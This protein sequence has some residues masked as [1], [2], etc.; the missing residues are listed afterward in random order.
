MDAAVAAALALG[1]HG[2]WIG[3]AFLVAEEGQTHAANKRQILEGRSQ[4]FEVNRYYTGKPSRMFTNAMLEAWQGSGLEPLPMPFQ[5][6]L[7]DDFNAS[8]AAAGR[9]EL[10]A[11]PAGQIAGMVRT[12][13]PAAEIFDDLVRGAV[14]VIE[15]SHACLGHQRRSRSH[16]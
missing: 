14:A 7:T 6:V 15:A 9:E 16:G 11:N 12:V 13:R 5:R 10:H 1:A 4:D 2:V 8:V 3:T